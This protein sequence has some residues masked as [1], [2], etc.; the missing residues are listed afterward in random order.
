MQRNR[1]VRVV[2]AIVAGLVFAAS[3]RAAPEILV[4]SNRADLISGG[5]ALVEIKWPAG[6]DTNNAQVTL[7]G[8]SVKSAFATRNGHYTGLVTGLGNGDNVLTASPQGGTAAQITITNHPITGPI[9]SGPHI[10]PYEC[11]LPDN[12]LV[13]TG[14]ADC[15]AMTQVEYF[16]AS[17]SNTFKPL[18]HPTGR[19]PRDL[20]Y[21]TTSDGNTVPYIVRAS[22][23]SRG[24]GGTASSWSPSAAAA[25]PSTTRAFK[26][27]PPR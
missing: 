25:Q 8:V 1:F 24:R 7:N 14:D 13:A 3:A 16:Y 22:P 20:V 17:R 6:T 18:D 4:L 5:D 21:T 11:R 19:R 2:F 12:N 10:T 27:S 9:L 26:G 23:P 15:S